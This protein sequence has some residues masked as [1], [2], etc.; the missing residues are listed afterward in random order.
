MRRLIPY[1][2]LVLLC[3]C[4]PLSILLFPPVETPEAELPVDAGDGEGDGEEQDA[5]EEPPTMAS[6]QLPPN[7]IYDS[8]NYST[9]TVD[10]LDDDP[11]APDG[12]FVD[13]DG[14]G[15]GQIGVDFA[16]PTVSG[17]LSGTQQFAIFARGEAA[18][19]QSPVIEIQVFEGPTLVISSLSMFV[20][21]PTG[22]LL[23]FNWDG[24]LVGN[25]ADVR[26]LVKLIE[27]GTGNQADLG[28]VAWVANSDSVA[29][30]GTDFQLVAPGASYNLVMP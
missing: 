7:A 29:V 27:S 11:F 16:T 9:A 22:K 20:D 1:A 2:L 8:S 30:A 24:A 3:G 21:N 18:G 19:V 14:G 26:C 4:V 12:T 13:P 25:S 15:D 10:I 17:P 23:T 6:Q 28:A 5:G